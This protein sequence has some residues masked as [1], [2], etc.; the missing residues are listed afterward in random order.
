MAVVAG[1][2]VAEGE[3]KTLASW[4]EAGERRSLETDT[5]T[6]AVLELTGRF[7]GEVPEPVVTR[8]ILE[9]VYL[10]LIETPA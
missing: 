3:P 6:R 2:I 10:R 4:S 7:G 9:D 8:P 5:P 1:G